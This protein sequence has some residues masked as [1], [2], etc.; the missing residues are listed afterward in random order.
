MVSLFIYKIT[1]VL[2]FYKSIKLKSTLNYPYI[3]LNN[4]SLNS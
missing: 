3:L 4:Y 1:K 2:Y